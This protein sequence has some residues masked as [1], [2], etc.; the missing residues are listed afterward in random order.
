M[1]PGKE[2]PRPFPFAFF[3]VPSVHSSLRVSQVVPGRFLVARLVGGNFTI[4]G[5]VPPGRCS[6]ITPRLSDS[7]EAF[8]LAWKRP[9]REL[10]VA[11]H[12]IPPRLDRPNIRLVFIDVAG[13]S[14]CGTPK[15]GVVLNRDWPV[16]FPSRRKPF[17]SPF[18]AHLCCSS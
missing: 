4:V 13:N 1:T 11:L 5:R 3:L 12:R 8:L 9:G 6:R 16:I 17:S 15:L 10:A 7:G 14:H 18:A 2:S